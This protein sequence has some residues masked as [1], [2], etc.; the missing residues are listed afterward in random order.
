MKSAAPHARMRFSTSAKSVSSGWAMSAVKQTTVTPASVSHFVTVQLSSPPDAAKATVWPFRSFTVTLTVG[1][2]FSVGIGVGLSNIY[3]R[4]PPLHTAPPFEEPARGRMGRPGTGHEDRP[5][6]HRLGPGLARH[7]RGLPDHGPGHAVLQRLLHSHRHPPRGPERGR[8][9][10]D[11][12]RGHRYLVPRA[13]RRSRSTA[14]SAGSASPGP[15]SR[16]SPCRWP[17][18]WSASWYSSSGWPW[19]ST[20]WPSCG[21]SCDR[22]VPPGDPA[23]DL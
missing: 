9:G 7:Q 11:R 6:G 1:S 23:A 3:G 21:C 22:P 18:S 5:P 13:D 4:R 17:V 8:G 12:G 16:R 14:G 20:S 15:R 2:G 10:P 19:A